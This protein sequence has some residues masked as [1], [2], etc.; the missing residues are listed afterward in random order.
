MATIGTF[1]KTAKGEFVGDI[2]TLS[3]QAKGVRIV[4]DQNPPSENAP[5][6]RVFV[7]NA[8]VGAAWAKHSNEGRAYLGLKLDDPSFNA[9]IYANLFDDDGGEAHSLIWSRPGRRGGD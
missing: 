8:E 2:V 3:L 5:T 9:P 4:P 1:K 6:H 7:G